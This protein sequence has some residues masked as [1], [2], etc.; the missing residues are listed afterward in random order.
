[1]LQELSAESRR[2][3]YKIS[4]TNVMVVDNTPLLVNNVLIENGQGY[5]HVHWTILHNQGKEPGQRGN[6]S[7]L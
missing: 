1:M 4:K 3:V 5:V 2:I 7:R 6:H